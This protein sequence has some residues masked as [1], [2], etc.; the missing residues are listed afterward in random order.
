M[1]INY[2]SMFNLLNA[3]IKEVEAGQL[4]QDTY[5]KDDVLNILKSIYWDVT[6]DENILE[7]Q[8]NTDDW[9][10]IFNK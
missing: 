3:K 5:T 4:S 7:K 1:T 9:M 6:I 8:V 2:S 10:D